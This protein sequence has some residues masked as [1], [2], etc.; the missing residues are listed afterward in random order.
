MYELNI[1]P[2]V[3]SGEKIPGIYHIII[4]AMESMGPNI[5]I[6]GLK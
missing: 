2:V 6:F 4:T 3:P 5:F 1:D